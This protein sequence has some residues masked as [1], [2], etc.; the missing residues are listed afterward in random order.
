MSQPIFAECIFNKECSMNSFSLWQKLKNILQNGLISFCQNVFLC[1]KSWMNCCDMVWF[2][3][4]RIF[5][6]MAEVQHFLHIGLIISANW[7]DKSSHCSFLS[8]TL[9]W[10]HSRKSSEQIWEPFWLQ[11]EH[12]GRCS[13]GG[14][15]DNCQWAKFG[16]FW[17]HSRGSHENLLEGKCLAFFQDQCC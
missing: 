6:I 17:F 5:F 16:T 9:L 3:P 14:I 13:S 12:G 10:K 7:N 11:A 4:A 1:S 8:E 15:W 2:L